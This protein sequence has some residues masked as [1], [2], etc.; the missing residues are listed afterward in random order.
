MMR[1]FVFPAVLFTLIIILIAIGGNAPGNDTS[2]NDS[3]S[4]VTPGITGAVNDIELLKPEVLTHF[5]PEAPA[6]DKPILRWTIPPGSVYFE[7]EFLTAYPENPNDIR[8]SA[9]RFFASREVYTNGYSVNLSQ[10]KDDLLYWR[11]RALDLD[12]N[13]VGVFSN[14]TPIYIDHNLPNILKPVANTG[15]NAAKMQ[16]PLYPV[17]SWIPIYGAVA[18]ELELTNAPPENPNGT[19]PS[20]YQIRMYAVNGPYDYYFAYYDQ[21]ALSTPGTYYWRVRGLDKAGGPVGVFSDA[22]QFTVSLEAGN[23]AATFGDSTTQGGGDMIYSPANVE[24][25]YRYYLKF[26]TMNLGKSADNAAGMLARFE[27][28]V[29]PF[30]PQFLIILGGIPELTEDVPAAQVIDELAAI[31]DKCRRHGIRPVFLTLYPVNP[32]NIK[33]TANHDTVSD[34]E[35]KFAQ[36]NTFLRKQKYCIDIE[37]YFQGADHNLPSY[38]SVDG[39]H[40]GIE[41]KK[42]MGQV[43]N[44]NWLRVTQ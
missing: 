2:T 4:P 40:L 8:P 20:K 33:R 1:R 34:W 28:D 39:I 24:S 37:P 38:L 15:Y 27:N 12:G 36:V 44:D 41:G 6:P 11:V 43:I 25:D 22:E 3:G 35:E 14:A 30:H 32:A 17:Y 29:L 16:M 9:H 23:Y 31:R 42:R 18:Y 21:V 26:P 19:S 13:P 7:I 10:Y 5:P